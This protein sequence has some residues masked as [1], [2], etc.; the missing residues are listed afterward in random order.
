MLEGALL[1]ECGEEGLLRGKPLIAASAPRTQ[2]D[3]GC[4][5]LSLRSFWKFTNTEP[6]LVFS[7]TYSSVA[8]KL[9]SR[10]KNHGER[11][12]ERTQKPERHLLV[13]QKSI[14]HFSLTPVRKYKLLEK[15]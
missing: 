2:E 5:P 11:N 6:T 10:E 9:G 1:K 3:S 12:V 4:P 7:S 15:L 14:A 8:V 13:G